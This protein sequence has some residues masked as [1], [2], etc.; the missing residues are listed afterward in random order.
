MKEYLSQLRQLVNQNARGLATRKMRLGVTGFARSGKTVFIGALTQALLAATNQHG[1]K[2]GPLQQFD[3]YEQGILRSVKICEQAQP[4]L[5][6]FPFRQVRDALLQQQ[7]QWPQPTSGISSLTLEFDFDS[8][9]A[10]SRFLQ[11]NLGLTELG[12]GKLQL[13]IVDFPGEWLVDLGMLGQSYQQWSDEVL[14]AAASGQRA[15]LSHE[16][17]HQLDGLDGQVLADD[18]LLEQLQQEWTSYLQ[19]AAQHG[20]TTNQ[21]GRHLRPDQLAGSPVLRFVPLPRRLASSALYQ[22]CQERFAAY[23]Q[24]VIKPFY[25]DVFSRM[26]SQ[27]VLVDVLRVLELGEEA[28]NDMQMSLTRILQNFDYGKGGLLSWLTGHKTTRV[29]FAAT[30]ADHVTRGDRR[31]LEELLRNMLAVVDDHNRLRGSARDWDV[32]ALASVRATEDRATTSEPVREVLYG[33]PAR[34]NEMAHWDPGGLPLDMPP[35]WESL[36]FRFY[37][38]NPLPYPQ[39]LQKGFPAINLGRAVQ[40]LVGDNVK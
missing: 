40:F 3:A 29:L 24:Q 9:Q 34:E 8:Q 14:V 27:L 23:Q 20:L 37:R 26:D 12:F 22:R 4:L 38:F 10:T 2:D 39:A 25:Q 18:A 11:E 36:R 17:R 30:K 5:A 28:F 21:P 31:N 1:R 19:A 32:M 13:E 15:G 7:N 33:C 6:Q 35:H 16:V